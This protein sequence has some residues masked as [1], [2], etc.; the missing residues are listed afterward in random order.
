M[1][2]IRAKSRLCGANRG[3]A[4]A[5]TL[6]QRGVVSNQARLRRLATATGA[7]QVAPASVHET[8]RGPGRPL[9]AAT[10]G[11]FEARFGADLGA[12]RLHD[13]A[14]AAQSARAVGALAYAA[15]PHVVIGEAA[16]DGRRARQLLAHELAHVI[17][18]GT[19][20]IPGRLEIGRTDAP[21]ERDAA[22]NAARALAGLPAEPRRGEAGV[23]RR[24]TPDDEIKKDAPP[25]L[26]LPGGNKFDIVPF[27]PL[28][29]GKGPTPFDKPGVVNDPSG[30]G[31]SLED[32]NSGLRSIFGKDKPR[33]G[34]NKTDQVPDCSVL[35]THDS[36]PTARKYK[37]FQQYDQERKIFHGPLTKDPWP[38]LSPGEYDQAIGNCP[39]SE[40]APEPE[41]P[42]PKL[43]REPAPLQ[44]APPPSLPPG[45][46][47]A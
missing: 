24:Q 5:A 7:G 35:E 19:A 10:R 42:L 3:A 37:T 30:K 17:Q 14:Q 16:Q 40:P 25:L 47:Y 6:S 32:L 27:L 21:E 36:T 11:V 1:T 33:Y 15:G 8:L 23:L 41:A 28:P 44:D 13:G 39:K 18:S 38:L 2:R 29:G 45:Q 9:D 20:A 31:P 43:P 4:T 34:L 12:V 26:P 22:A 46:A